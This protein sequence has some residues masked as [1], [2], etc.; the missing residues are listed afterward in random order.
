[1]GALVNALHNFD[2]DTG[3]DPQLL[4][5]LNTYWEQ[6]RELYSPFECNMKAVSSDVYQH[7]MPG[8][9]VWMVWG[10]NRGVSHEVCMDASCNVALCMWQHTAMSSAVLDLNFLLDNPRPASPA[11]PL[12]YTNLKFQ[13]ASLGLGSK[14]EW[15]RIC[16]AYA[17]ANRALGDIVKVTPSSKVW[18]CVGRGHGEQGLHKDAAWLRIMDESALVDRRCLQWWLLQSM[19]VVANFLM[20]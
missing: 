9:Q 16:T 13:A 18:K 17:G 20:T 11:V 7:E 2:L 4:L 19:L 5:P 12:Q 1:M 15:E 6:T 10:P 14:E 8:G 3:L